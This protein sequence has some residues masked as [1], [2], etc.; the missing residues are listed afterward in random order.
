MLHNPDVLL[1][2]TSVYK[3]LIDLKKRNLCEYIGISFY[4]Y[5][6]FFLY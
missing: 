4:N 5:N 3:R 6:N 2:N 1:K